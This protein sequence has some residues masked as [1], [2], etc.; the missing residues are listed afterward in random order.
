MSSKNAYPKDMSTM[1][2]GNTFFRTTLVPLLLMLVSPP[3]VQL[4]W[5]A[6][7]H[8][9]GSIVKTILTPLQTLWQQFPT[10]TLTA[11][12]LILAFLFSQFLLLVLVPGPTFVAIPTPMGNLP[13]YKLN[14]VLSFII[15][16]FS[17]ALAAYF[18]FIRYGALYDSFGPILAFLNKIALV[19]TFCLYIRGIYYP[20]NS[21]SGT[22]GYGII[23]DIWH[24]TELHPEI[25]G[26]SLKQLINC[27]FALMGWSVAVIAFAA[28]Q[29][30][31]YGANAN[32]MLV[33]A[34][35]QMIYIFKFFMWEGGYFNSVCL[36]TVLTLLL[37][38]AISSFVDI[39]NVSLTL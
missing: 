13:K 29:Y 19:A 14:G 31:I 30:E 38:N 27:R 23:W 21:D 18:G 26:V 37:F 3:A 5:V 16:H 39:Q 1:E 9:N 33:S 20:T 2:K 35:L 25:Y 10:P 24:G 34:A 17:L 15:T 4:V 36:L 6:C 28:K 32:S 12:T 8:H 11:V 7:Y 22:T